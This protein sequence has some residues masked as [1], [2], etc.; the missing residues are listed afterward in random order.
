MNAP[1]IETTEL[2]PRVAIVSDG[3]ASAARSG[4]FDARAVLPRLRARADLFDQLVEINAVP[5][6]VEFHNVDH[7]VDEVAALAGGY[8]GV[9]LAEIASPRCLIV[10]ERLG[11]QVSVPVVHEA[12]EPAAVV[13]F[14]AVCNALTLVGTAI[15]DAKVVVAGT[16]ATHVAVANLFQAYGIAVTLVMPEPSARLHLKIVTEYLDGVRLS[17]ERTPEASFAGADVL[18]AGPLSSPLD[19]ALA[20]M[21]PQPIVMLL[22]SNVEGMR[23]ARVQ[24]DEGRI[25]VLATQSSELPNWLDSTLVYP[26]AMRGLTDV[27]AASFT[28]GMQIAAALSLAR[29]VEVG[30]HPQTILPEA[31]DPRA[32]SAV[33][34]AIRAATTVSA[35]HDARPTPG[36]APT[37]LSTR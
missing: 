34:G 19:D 28:P 20:R 26:G 17:V 27:G 2:R 22:D 16:G 23:I 10:R 36:D 5:I 31:R 7:L 25:A 13:I 35:R 18:I 8:R 21:A 33:A 14:A 1:S 9:L 29:L 15:D 24:A 30:R 11:R 32:A 12:H 4:H 37:A 6:C 3:S